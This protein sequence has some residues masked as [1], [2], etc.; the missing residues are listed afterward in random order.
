MLYGCVIKYTGIDVALSSSGELEDTKNA[1]AG[2]S[3]AASNKQSENSVERSEEDDS[4]SLVDSMPLSAAR[5]KKT[6]SM[7]TALD[8]IRLKCTRCYREQ[9]VMLIN[10]ER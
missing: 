7:A 2:T 6:H 9:E 8:G 4:H 10:K 3:D 5:A 1:V